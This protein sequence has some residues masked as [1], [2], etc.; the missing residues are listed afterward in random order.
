MSATLALDHWDASQTLMERIESLLCDR[1]LPFDRPLDGEII[2]EV[3]GAWCNLR[4]WLSWEPL[5][6]VF[7]ITA[8]YEQRIPATRRSVL[9]PLLSQINERMVMGHFEMACEDGT[10]FFRCGQLVKDTAS[11]TPELLEALM[12]LAVCE[13]E[14]FYPAF[15][16]ALWNRQH[17]QASI[18]LALMEPEGEG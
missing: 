7:M 11:L 8:S 9:Q 3:A 16:S 12:D 14:R 17:D 13:C 15:Q 1:N 10:L 18:E 5:C 2:T 6:E 4:L